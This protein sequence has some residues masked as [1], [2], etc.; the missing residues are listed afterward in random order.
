MK[1]PVFEVTRTRMLVE[2]CTVEAKTPSEA[3][4]LAEK[5]HPDAWRVREQECLTVNACE[6][7]P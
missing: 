7:R 4:K 2:V 1:L 6:V 5:A 3:V